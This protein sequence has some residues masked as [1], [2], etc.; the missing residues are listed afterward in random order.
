MGAMFRPKE[1]KALNTA[2]GT[3]AVVSLIAFVATFF[4]CCV[5]ALQLDLIPFSFG[6]PPPETWGD[7]LVELSILAVPC[8][9]AWIVMKLTYRF[10]RGLQL[11]G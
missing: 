3:A 11:R 4:A 10:F 8:I 9:I 5:I 7:R 1:E 6:V 2:I